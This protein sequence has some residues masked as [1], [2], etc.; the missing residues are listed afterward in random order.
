MFILTHSAGKSVG[1]LYLYS[2]L[3]SE[4][5]LLIVAQFLYEV[6][7]WKIVIAI[8]LLKQKHCDL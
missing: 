5:K 3:Q 4:S 6:C 7:R 8:T 1:T 2:D